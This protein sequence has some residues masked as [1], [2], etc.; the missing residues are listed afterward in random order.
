MAKEGHY[1]VEVHFWSV[2]CGRAVDEYE[3]WHFQH[4]KAIFWIILL[5]R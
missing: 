3:F 1:S 5:H 4:L 2:N